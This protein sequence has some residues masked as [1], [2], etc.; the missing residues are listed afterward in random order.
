LI[1]TWIHIA[2]LKQ[3]PAMLKWVFEL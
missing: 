1:Y 2:K 3:I